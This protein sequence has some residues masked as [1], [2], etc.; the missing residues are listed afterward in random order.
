MQSFFFFFF[1]LSC[2]CIFLIFI[3]TF[4]KTAM[5][6]FINYICFFFL[7]KKELFGGHFLRNMPKRWVNKCFVLYKINKIIYII[8]LHFCVCRI[9]VQFNINIVSVL[10]WHDYTIKIVKS[11]KKKNCFCISNTEFPPNCFRRVLHL[12]C[13]FIEWIALLLLLI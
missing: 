4:Y 3:N 5:A 8:N 11:L 13:L 7:R 12:A 10:V 1:F 2:V 9:L 6:L